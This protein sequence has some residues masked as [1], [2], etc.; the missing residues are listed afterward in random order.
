M[1][2]KRRLL[3]LGAVVGGLT[4]LYGPGLIRWVEIKVQKL[5]LS[6]EIAELRLQNFRLWQEA[7]RLR[8]DPAYAEAVARQ[9]LGFVRPGETV[10]RIKEEG[11][12]R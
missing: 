7:K 12:S 6:S 2:P 3:I 4:V 9:K 10:I 8:E 5:Q 1:S 11:S